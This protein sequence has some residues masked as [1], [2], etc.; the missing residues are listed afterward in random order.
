MHG[1]VRVLIGLLA[2][3]LAIPALAQ[4]FPLHPDDTL[5]PG[6]VASTDGNDVCGIV[7]GLSYSRRH[8]HTSPELKR[9]VYAAYYVDPAGREFEV[10]HRVPVCLGGA[11]IR[12]NLWPQEGCFG[13]ERRDLRVTTRGS[14]RAFCA[15]GGRADGGRQAR[16][17]QSALPRQIDEWLAGEPCRRDQINRIGLPKLWAALVAKRDAHLNLVVC[18]ACRTAPR[19]S[20]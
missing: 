2:I 6:A 8:R 12:E 1:F 20:A 14:A 19:G 16:A 10:D 15:F 9:E 5:T 13:A 4:D 3:G 7:D 11:D 17:R 18:R